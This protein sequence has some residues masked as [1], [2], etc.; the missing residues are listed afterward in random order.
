MTVAEITAILKNA[1]IE[2]AAH[3]AFLIM[4]HFSK[5]SRAYLIADKDFSFT[6]KEMEKAV[7]K[8]SERYPLQYI[9]GEWEFCGLPFAVNEN[10]KVYLDIS[11]NRFTTVFPAC[12]SSNSAIELTIAEL[13]QYSNYIKMVD[14]CKNWQNEEEQV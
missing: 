8:R 2:E 12:G 5:K 3:E 4:E 7:Q 6:S 13:K 11:L 10:A 1:G 9:F 14:V